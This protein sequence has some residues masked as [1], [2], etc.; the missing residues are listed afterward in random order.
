[1]QTKAGF[2]AANVLSISARTEKHEDFVILPSRH[3]H[4]IRCAER[5]NI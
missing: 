1:M 2:N 3:R 4:F 5:V